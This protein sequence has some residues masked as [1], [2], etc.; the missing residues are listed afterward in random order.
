MGVHYIPL[1]AESILWRFANLEDDLI[2]VLA[3][4]EPVSAFTHQIT[5]HPALR[6]GTPRDRWSEVNV[7]RKRRVGSP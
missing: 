1:T 7:K 3:H 6:D 4:D 5:L 2:A